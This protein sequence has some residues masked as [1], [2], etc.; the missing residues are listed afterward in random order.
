MKVLMELVVYHMTASRL[1]TDHFIEFLK[2]VF[3]NVNS[4]I[5]TVSIFCDMDMFGFVIHL[6]GIFQV[7]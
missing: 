6:S 3:A 4:K 5:Y 1:K 2:N 7:N